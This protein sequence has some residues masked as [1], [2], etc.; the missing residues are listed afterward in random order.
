MTLTEIKK[1]LYKQKPTATFHHCRK[2][3]NGVY[4]VYVCEIGGNTGIPDVFFEIP[5]EELGDGL[6]FAEMESQLLIR[7]IVQPET[8]QP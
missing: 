7:Y 6:F 8:K 4:L 5:V 2:S 1:A 3:L